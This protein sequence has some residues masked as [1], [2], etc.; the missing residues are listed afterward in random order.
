MFFS[1]LTSPHRLR[2]AAHLFIIRYSEVKPSE[3][4]ADNFYSSAFDLEVRGAVSS[5]N[6]AY[7][8]H[9]A[10]TDKIFTLTYVSD[11]QMVSS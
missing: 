2:D 1:S 11:C 6:S 10:G 9:V 7:V 4:A 3:L 8:C 5:L